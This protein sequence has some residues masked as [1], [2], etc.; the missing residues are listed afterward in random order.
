MYDNFIISK[1]FNCGTDTEDN[2]GKFQGV[3]IAELATVFI[4]T[5]SDEEISNLKLK[6][7]AEAIGLDIALLAREFKLD[8][9]ITFERFVEREKMYRAIYAL[10]KE[11]NITIHNLAK[12]LG[13]S[14][15]HDFT[16]VFERYNLIEPQ[17]FKE[18]VKKRN[19]DTYHNW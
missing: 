3:N 13:Y 17:K 16:E 19:Q 8:Q 10:E 15:V 1:F 7:A 5:R 6:D 18:I 9:K 12:R 4:L 2:N 11:R 14:T